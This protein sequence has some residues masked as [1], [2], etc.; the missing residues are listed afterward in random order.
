MPQAVEPVRAITLADIQ[1]ARAR[2]A[3]TI[4]RTPLVRLDLGPESP[5][6]FL[7]LE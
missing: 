3:K 5:K 6:I 2:I 1:E 4:V 7:K